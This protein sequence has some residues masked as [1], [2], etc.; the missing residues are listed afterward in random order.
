M[1]QNRK[2]QPIQTALRTQTRT[3]ILHADPVPAAQ[4]I[5]MSDEQQQYSLDNQQQAIKEYADSFGFAVVKTYPDPAK[6]GV[7]AKHR[8][9]QAATKRRAVRKCQLQS[10]FGVRRV[11]LGA[12]S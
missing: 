12:F 4:Y 2:A 1:L 10:H 6:T 5:R 7:E 11:A 3:T 8:P 9:G